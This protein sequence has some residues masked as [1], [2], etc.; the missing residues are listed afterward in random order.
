MTVL[1]IP[2][3]EHRPVPQEQLLEYQS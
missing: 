1:G 3:R 2:A